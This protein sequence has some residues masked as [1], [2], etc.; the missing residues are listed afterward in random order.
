VPAQHELT[1]PLVPRRRLLGLA[2]GAVN[3]MR[4]G[5]GS[6]VASSR[7][8]EP[9]DDVGAI[10]WSASARRSAARDADEFIVREHF[11]E[12]APRVVI[13]CDRRPEM[14]L[15]PDDLPWL[16]KPAVMI[17]AGRQIA[18]S[19]AKARGL[20]GYLDYAGGEDPFWRPPHSQN[21]FARVKESHLLWP[22]Y[23]A[24]QDNLARALLHLVHSRRAALRLP[25]P[26]PARGLGDAQRAAVDHGAGGHPG[27][28]VGAELPRGR[29]GRR[30][31]PRPRD[32][33]AEAGSAQPPQGAA[34]Q[35]RARGPA[36][37]P[38][39]GAPQLRPLPRPA[40]GR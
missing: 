12:E 18:D 24:P 21:D 1:F 39:R 20:V 19:A 14:A 7:L 27:P 40:L 16:S 4:R 32:E 30:P 2:F 35:A 10:D 9:G 28:D 3:S 36:R 31:A 34:A 13:V 17:E 6:D 22:A 26:A 11:A 25:R 38:A 33:E 23:G 8:Y 5:R 37:A 29:V 15:Y